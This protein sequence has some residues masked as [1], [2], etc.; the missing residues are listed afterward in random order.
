[1][2]GRR[3]VIANLLRAINERFPECGYILPE[4]ANNHI[5]AVEPEIAEV[6]GSA[7]QLQL[8]A[9]GSAIVFYDGPGGFFV[10]RVDV[11]NENFTERD[12][13][14]FVPLRRLIVTENNVA[15]AAAVLILL[16]ERHGLRKAIRKAEM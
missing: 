5:A 6:L 3:I 12:A 8:G 4:F 15:V 16:A 1:M 7:V 11:T 14:P 9:F 13:V 2:S 10:M